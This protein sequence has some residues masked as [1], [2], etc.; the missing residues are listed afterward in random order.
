MKKI[1][2]YLFCFIIMLS[3]ASC[4]KEDYIGLD[5]AK[6]TVVSDIGAVI[7]DV[8]FAVNELVNDDS[9]DYYHLKFK[10]DGKMYT[11]KVDAMSGEIIEKDF[12]DDYDDNSETTT[13]DNT[14]NAMMDE[15]TDSILNNKETEKSSTAE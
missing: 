11:Y 9:G 5:K 2:S 7:G 6:D 14:D 3:F 13:A 12:D 1:I 4:G 8:E 10:K 15:I